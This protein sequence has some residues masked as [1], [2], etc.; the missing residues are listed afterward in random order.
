VIVGREILKELDI[1]MSFKNE[2]IEW[3]DVIIPMKPDT[4]KIE[5]HFHIAD[6][7]QNDD[8]SKRIK[9]ILHAEYKT[10]DLRNIFTDR[11]HLS[12][13]EKH[14]L[15]V[16]LNKHKTLFDGSLGTWKNEQY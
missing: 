14:D 9:R 6:S 5:E 12:T 10:A 16:I 15:H 1:L 7:F 8:A 2:T 4:A 13:N 3:D 11:T